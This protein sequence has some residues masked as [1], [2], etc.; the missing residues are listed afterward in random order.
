MLW[1]FTVDRPPS[2]DGRPSEAYR[3]IVIAETVQ[4]L[5]DV[6]GKDYT[7]ERDEEGALPSSD[8]PVSACG[9][10]AKHL[11]MRYSTLCRIWEAW[12][13]PMRAAQ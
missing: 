1:W 10:V 8:T 4:G 9:V 5:H 7:S 13:T 3:N 12:R 2:R 11:K 6:S